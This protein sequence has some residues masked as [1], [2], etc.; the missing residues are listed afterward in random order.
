LF[1]FNVAV[2]L[3]AAIPQLAQVSSLRGLTELIVSPGWRFAVLVL[4]SVGATYLILAHRLWW[5]Y[6]A[7]F[8]AQ[9]GYFFFVSSPDKQILFISVLMA[10]GVITQPPMRPL[11]PLAAE[12]AAMTIAFSYIMIVYCLYSAAWAVNGGRVPRGACGPRLSPFEPFRASRLL[13]TLLPVGRHHRTSHASM[14]H[15]LRCLRTCS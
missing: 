14:R 3:W 13:D 15:F 11:G 7:I 10:Y 8:L 12:L 2:F 5:V 1:I 4:G 6:A 9:V